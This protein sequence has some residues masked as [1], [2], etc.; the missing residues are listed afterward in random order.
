MTQLRA[1]HSN[2]G[3]SGMSRWAR[4]PGSYKLSRDTAL[5]PRPSIYAAA[6]TVAHDLIEASLARPNFEDFADTVR[7]E[8]REVEGH[9]VTIDDDMLAGVAV[10]DNYVRQI[11]LGFETMWVET[12]VSLDSYFPKNF[13]APEPL[14]G[15]AD[16]V[17]VST[18]NRHMEVIDYKHGRGL[19]V[20]V[21]DNQQLL[22][23]AA[24][25]LRQLAP[26]DAAKIDRI[27]LT[28]VQ[29]RLDPDNSIKSWTT[30]ALDVE[31][32]VDAV[33]IPAVRAASEPNAPL[34]PGTWCRFCPAARVCPRLEEAA[35][36]AAMTSF[37]PIE[38]AMLDKDPLPDDLEIAERAET[39]IEAVRAHAF[40]VLGKGHQV[41]GWALVPK[42]PVRFWPNPNQVRDILAKQVNDMD[43][44]VHSE[45]RSPAQVE[46]A[47]KARP[48]LWGQVAGHVESASSGMKL[49][50][51]KPDPRQPQETD[52]HG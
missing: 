12:R 29:P 10:M 35:I 47:L 49:A 3:A 18:K 5:S 4:C 16:V 39:W 20:G 26:A 46:K 31:L 50:R 11:A 33:L 13:P 43:P 41:P 7:G 48:D 22:Y 36:Q 21:E 32:W 37:D 14:F 40:E 8:V 1:Q 24:G 45:L 34:N 17:L 23:Y 52:Q 44:F 25:A 27:A 42:R 51:A 19:A 2:L 30:S 38:A 6:G 28:V 9:S 15:R